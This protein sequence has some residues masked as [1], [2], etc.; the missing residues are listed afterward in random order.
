MDFPQHTLSLTEIIPLLAFAN[1]KV[2]K[3]SLKR[4]IV[5]R[6]ALF[7]I[8]LRVAHSGLLVEP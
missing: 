7:E 5:P 4:Y 3:L 2:R 8:V 6:D 1:K